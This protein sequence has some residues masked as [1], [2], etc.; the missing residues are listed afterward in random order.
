MVKSVHFKKTVVQISFISK[1]WYFQYKSRQKVPQFWKKRDSRNCLLRMNGLF[2]LHKNILGHKVDQTCSSSQTKFLP[3]KV[4][5]RH[6][7][8]GHF[9]RGREDLKSVTLCVNLQYNTLGCLD[10]GTN[11]SPTKG[12]MFLVLF[13]FHDFLQNSLQKSFQFIFLFCL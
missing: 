3:L 12:L 4:N 7:L 10:D 11:E 1:L 8:V 6:T 13:F 5:S 9:P 2:F